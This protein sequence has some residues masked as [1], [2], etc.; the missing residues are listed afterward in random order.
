MGIAPKHRPT[1]YAPARVS[2]AGCSH[3]LGR[4]TLGV[5]IVATVDGVVPRTPV[6]VLNTVLIRHR[7]AF[8]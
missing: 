1:A 4:D 5:R 3:L 8:A 2:A 6:Q 7:A